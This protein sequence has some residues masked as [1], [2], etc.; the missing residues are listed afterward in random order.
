MERS[1][2]PQNIPIN[3]LELGN[4][5]FFSCQ[6]F[7]INLLLVEAV[8]GFVNAFIFVTSNFDSHFPAL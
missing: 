1:S 4:N 2:F 3:L 8:F 7:L 6:T 5:L